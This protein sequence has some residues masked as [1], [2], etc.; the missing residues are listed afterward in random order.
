ANDQVIDTVEDYEMGRIT[1]SMAL[2]QLA[3]KKPN[4]QLCV[5]NQEIIAKCLVFDNSYTVKGED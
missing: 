5:R 2:D 3:Y 4:H 1:G